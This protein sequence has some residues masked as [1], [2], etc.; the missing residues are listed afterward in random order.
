MTEQPIA[1][2]TV[3]VD[4]DACPNV[5]KEILFRA[6]DRKQIPTVL[7]ANQFLRVPQSAYI[8]SVQVAS[9]F[10]VADNYIAA[11][12]QGMIWSSLQTFRWLLKLSKKVCLR[13]IPVGSFILL[14]T[15]ASV[16]ICGTSWLNCETQ[17]WSVVARQNLASRSGSNSPINW[18]VCSQNCFVSVKFPY[19]S[20]GVFLR[21]LL[22]DRY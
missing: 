3:W 10:D 15:S 8:R 4:A 22:P 5:I 20:L 12:C 11:H 6:A 9:G 1:P 21:F 18:T 13:L 7:V 17:V 16:L 19:T 2:L 14:K